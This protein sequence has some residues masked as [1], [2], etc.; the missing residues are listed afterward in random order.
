[1]AYLALCLSFAQDG[2]D[3]M[4]FF[5]GCDSHESLNLLDV[6]ATLFLSVIL[7]ISHSAQDLY[8][9][10]GHI[11][12]KTTGLNSC[13]PGGMFP[14]GL[15]LVHGL[16]GTGKHH[17]CG[18]YLDTHASQEHLHFRPLGD[19]LASLVSFLGIGQGFGKGAFHN[20]RCHGCLGHTHSVR[21][22]VK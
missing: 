14:L 13:R 19:F 16:A 15:F 18:L 9:V 10:R 4:N 20:S 7:H 8:S 1:M 6:P 11:A 12:G 2:S 17:F 5:H 22:L 3:V 21:N